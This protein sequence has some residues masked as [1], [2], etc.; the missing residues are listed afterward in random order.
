VAT[1]ADGEGAIEKITE[2]KAAG[3]QFSAVILDL[4]IPGKMGGKETTK[5]LLRIEPN[6][7]AVVASGYSDDQVM[8]DYEAYGLKAAIAKPYTIAELAKVLLT[9]LNKNQRT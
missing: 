6:I 8:T 2:A 4:I 5:Q 1:S 3:I 9:I 7:V